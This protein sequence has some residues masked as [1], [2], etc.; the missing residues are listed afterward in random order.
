M[1]RVSALT[2]WAFRYSVRTIVTPKG[3]AGFRTASLAAR[4]SCGL[5]VSSVLAVP[6]A[7]P[8]IHAARPIIRASLERFAR[9]RKTIFRPS[10]MP[11]GGHDVDPRP[12]ARGN[13]GRH[14]RHQRQRY[15]YSQ[16]GPWFTP[17][18][19]SQGY[20]IDST[21]RRPGET[22]MIDGKGQ[23]ESCDNAEDGSCETQQHPLGHEDLADP[24][25]TQPD[26]A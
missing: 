21:R 4:I 15:C 12:T 11:Q 5:R 13:P 22:A 7:G 23:D 26:G 9:L 20:R 24:G 19:D 2:S 25:A 10:R 18:T 8:P 17:N 3:F 14:D 1:A 6:T 16:H